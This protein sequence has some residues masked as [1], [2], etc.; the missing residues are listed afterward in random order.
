MEAATPALPGEPQEAP[1][2]GRRL[3]SLWPHPPQPGR[4]LAS[5]VVS[6]A[7][8]LALTLV[9][10]LLRRH[11]PLDL[12]NQWDSRWYIGIALHGY[13]WG[14]AGKPSLAFYPLYPLLIRGLSYTGLPA[15]GA[16]LLIAN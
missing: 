7:L 4:L 10:A 9:V 11:A 13:H 8:L 16:A 12:W 6:R 2:T 15:I 14:I 3:R 5:F 1:S